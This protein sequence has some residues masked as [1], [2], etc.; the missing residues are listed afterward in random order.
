MNVY[1]VVVSEVRVGD[2]N[3]SGSNNGI[4]ES[5]LTL[6]HGDMVKPNVRRTVYRQTV[7]IGSS[8]HSE[9]VRRVTDHTTA[10]LRYVVNM[11][12]M[13]NNMSNKLHRDPR[14]MRDMDISSSRIDGL[15]AINQKLLV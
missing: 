1:V 2:C 15:E 4:N 13:D 8:P 9:M 6:R 14:A 7:P 11:Q 3:G 10:T 12:P 5:I